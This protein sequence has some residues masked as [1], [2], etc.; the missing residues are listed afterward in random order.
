M[1]LWLVSCTLKDNPVD[2]SDKGFSTSLF[3]A[4]D[5]HETGKG[6]NL[7]YQSDG[8]SVISQRDFCYNKRINNG[9]KVVIK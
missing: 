8:S 6:N 4:T 2:N 9:K 5:R 7:I 1:V 3:V